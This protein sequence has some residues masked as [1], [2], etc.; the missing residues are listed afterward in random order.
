MQIEK[1]HEMQQDVISDFKEKLVKSY[2]LQQF[3]ILFNIILNSCGK[4]SPPHP[5]HLNDNLC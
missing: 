1:N 5:K 3:S 4:L 2:T